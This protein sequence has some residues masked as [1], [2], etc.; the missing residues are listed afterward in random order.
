MTQEEKK[1]IQIIRTHHDPVKGLI[2]AIN[3]VKCFLAQT[4]EKDVV[5]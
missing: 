2:I 4:T 1:L 5:A 3:I